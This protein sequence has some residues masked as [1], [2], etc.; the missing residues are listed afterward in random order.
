MGG[1]SIV[2]TK[3][4]PAIKK[5]KKCAKCLP[6]I[7]LYQF[8]FILTKGQSTYKRPKPNY[9]RYFR[10]KLPSEHQVSTFEINI[11]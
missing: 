3:I 8:I 4:R 10:K 1:K 11:Q 2:K 5:T 6:N 7:N 9:N